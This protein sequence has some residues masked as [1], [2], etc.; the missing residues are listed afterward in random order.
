LKGRLKSIIVIVIAL[1]IAIATGFYL[2]PKDVEKTRQTTTVVRL[3]QNIGKNQQIKEEHLDVIEIGSYNLPKYIVTNSN[4]IIG[5]YATVPMYLGEFAIRKYFQDEKVP[6]N[7]FLYEDTSVDGISFE[8]DLAKCVG[9][10]PEKGDRVRVIIYKQ[11]KD[12]ET[13]SEVLTC[14]ELSNL[15]VIKVANK[16]GI[17]IE[18]AKESEENSNNSIVPGVVTVKAD[19][20]QQQLLVKGVYDG[21]IHLALRP[22]I[23]QDKK[24]KIQAENS[25][26]EDNTI[27]SN[28]SH[29][30]EDS[31]KQNKQEIKESTTNETIQETEPV[32]PKK[33]NNSN[34]GGFKVDD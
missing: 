18:E 29:K 33:D 27:S 25:N 5:K 19:M 23:L 9:G 3:K 16:N 30:R 14:D 21:I 32:A 8:T 20:K 2:V 11:A 6:E 10:I 1:A 12:R 15:E 26:K 7:A 24:E 17:S 13:E 4:E 28:E 34:G 22:R 31:N